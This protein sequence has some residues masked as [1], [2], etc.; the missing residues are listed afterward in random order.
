MGSGVRDETLTNESISRDGT[1]SNLAGDER[2]VKPVVSAVSPLIMN[3]VL[4][5]LAHL[6]EIDLMRSI[7]L[8]DMPR[9]RCYPH[10]PS[11]ITLITAL[12]A[13]EQQVEAFHIFSQVWNSCIAY[14][15]G[16]RG[17]LRPKKSEVEALVD[18]TLQ[19]CAR[20]LLLR[21][22]NSSLFFQLGIVA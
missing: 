15:P 3:S 7:V 17:T 19:A 6:G 1:P 2:E 4:S 13:A 9:R 22:V 5:S 18:C 14:P 8:E 10:L 20:Y 16:G 12:N 11:Y 21:T